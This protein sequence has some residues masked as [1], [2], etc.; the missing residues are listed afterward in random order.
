[1]FETTPLTRTISNHPFIVILEILS[2]S[3]SFD[4]TVL[5][6]NWRNKFRYFQQVTTTPSTPHSSWINEIATVIPND[7]FHFSIE[8][9]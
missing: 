1:M 2:V 3:A 9:E 8:T 4:E 7:E 6:G 5:S